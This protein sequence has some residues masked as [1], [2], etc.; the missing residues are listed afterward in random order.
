MVFCNYHP[1]MPR[2]HAIVLFILSYFEEPRG[3]FTIPR[4]VADNVPL[5]FVLATRF[6]GQ[7]DLVVDYCGE[8][9]SLSGILKSNRGLSMTQVPSR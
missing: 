8:G 6:G 3:G 5:R 1:S 2:S 4:H 9:T 7:T